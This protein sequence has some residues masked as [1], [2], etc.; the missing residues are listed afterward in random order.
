MSDPTD[1]AAAVAAGLAALDRVGADCSRTMRSRLLCSGGL[2]SSRQNYLQV[3]GAMKVV[4]DLA[5]PL[6]LRAG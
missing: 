2:H 4:D 1:R 6:D 3:A 5:F